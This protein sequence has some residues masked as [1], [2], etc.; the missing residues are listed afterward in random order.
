[1]AAP[2]DEQVDEEKV[3]V[4]DDYY[5]TL[6]VS[7]TAT[8]EE[9]VNAFRK[10]S[11]IY[12]PDKHRDPASQ[13]D[14]K[15]IFN[16][17]RYAHDVLVDP[18]RRAI[19]DTLGPEGLDTSGWQVTLKTK[20]PQEIREEYERLAKEQA[21]RH[22]RQRTNPTG[23]ISMEIDATDIFDTYDDDEEYPEFESTS[24][25]DSLPELE[26]GR[27]VVRQTVEAPLSTTDSLKFSGSLVAQKGR[28][29][30][31]IT[32]M[33]RHV[34]SNTICTEVE[35]GS[36]RGLSASAKLVKPIDA[37]HIITGQLDLQRTARGYMPGLSVVLTR[38]LTSNIVGYLTWREGHTQS[39]TASFVWRSSNSQAAC[40]IQL[41]IPNSFI[42]MKYTHQMWEHTKFDVS[43][44]LGT[45]NMQ[46]LYGC[47]TEISKHNKVNALMKISHPEGV[48]LKLTFMRGNQTFAF[49]IQLSQEVHP[50]AIFYG[51]VVPMVGYLIFKKFLV[52]P[53]YARQRREEAEK[54]REANMSK[55]AE[56]RKHAEAATALM[57]QTYQRCCE[58]EES[59]NGLIIVSAKYGKSDE[60][61]GR[62]EDASRE[63]IE[64]TIP[65]QILVVNS[66]LTLSE[67]SKA[68]LLGFYDPCL[69]EEKS[70]RIT[71]KF[72]G[73]QYEVVI[74]D[75]ESLRI[76]QE[77]HL[78]RPA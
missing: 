78:V 16:K 52:E 4:K 51:T 73:L 32:T 48:T 7:S 20:T 42:E 71:Y 19:Y 74:K 18:Q 39:M 11:R 17:I 38:Q 57:K 33:W 61:D 69:G 5:A 67:T 37:K 36:D 75:L 66:C 40:D 27:M 53:Y 60:I 77:K 43:G 72:R 70:L 59:R 45:L 23:T 62:E 54:I 58:V 50:G 6:N 65:L 64:V 49:P 8:T 68:N 25:F 15:T 56:L 1:M 10:L 14:A 24:P 13:D 9:I 63:I 47:Q 30:G 76:P 44:R 31:R 22:L 55:I 3:K 12:H 29:E 41:G 2:S 34:F 21:E 35:L 26:V 28:G 46:F